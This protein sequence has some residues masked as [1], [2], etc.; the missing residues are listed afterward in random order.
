MLDTHGFKTAGRNG[1]H[2]FYIILSSFRETSKK[3]NRKWCYKQE[4]H[5]NCHLDEPSN[6]FC[7]W[8]TKLQTTCTTSLLCHDLKVLSFFPLLF[9]HFPHAEQ[10]RAWQPPLAISHTQ[11]CSI[12]KRHYFCSCSFHLKRKWYEILVCWCCLKSYTGIFVVLVTTQ[13]NQFPQISWWSVFGYNLKQASDCM[14]L[15]NPCK[16]ETA[17]VSQ[18]NP[19][20]ICRCQ[21]DLQ[22]L[23]KVQEPK[24][25]PKSFTYPSTSKCCS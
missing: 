16:E 14:P 15:L 9:S 1:K 3:K 5:L 6:I 19:H 17:H 4:A 12:T 21:P 7:P 24:S 13:S 8:C 20:L 25:Y 22:F 2:S 10:W 23:Y 18:P 11:F